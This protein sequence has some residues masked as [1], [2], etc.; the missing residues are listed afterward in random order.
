MT[1]FLHIIAENSRI[2]DCVIRVR[3]YNDIRRHTKPDSRA[4]VPCM[5]IRLVPIDNPWNARYAS[6]RPSRN[7]AVTDLSVTCL[8][9]I[10]FGLDLFISFFVFSF[11][12][13][14]SHLLLPF[15]ICLLVIVSLIQGSQ[16]S[17]QIDPRKKGKANLQRR[18][19]TFQ[20]GKD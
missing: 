4:K 19:W 14:L 13:W 8:S 6:T 17:I 7:M 10:N 20:C 11:F 18:N 9:E 5:N 3:S 2:T 1:T 16:N 15:P 12:P